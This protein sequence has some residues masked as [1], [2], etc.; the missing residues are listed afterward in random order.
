MSAAPVVRARRADWAKAI[1]RVP[2][3]SPTRLV[4]GRLPDYVDASGFGTVNPHELA[5]CSCLPLVPVL[6]ALDLLEA[7]GWLAVDGDDLVLT[8]PAS[9]KAET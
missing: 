1:A 5:A 6:N 7:L 3:D 8:V 4:R 2:A 9:A